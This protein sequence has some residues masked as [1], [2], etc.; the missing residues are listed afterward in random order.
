MQE[1]IKHIES[2]IIDQFLMEDNNRPW[3][4]GFSGG[5]DSTMLLQMVWNALKKIDPIVRS[6]RK[7]YV[8][9]NDTLVENPKIVD[10]I[11]RTLANIEK[12][13]VRDG[14]SLLVEKT[15]PKL[16]DTF[17]VNVIGR[18]YPAPNSIFRWCTERLKINPTTKRILDKID[19]N[20][21]VILFLGT[22]SDESIKRASSIKKHEF[23]TNR[24]RKH[25]L[26]KAFVYTP[27][28]DFLTEEVWQYL[29]AVPSPW[30]GSNRELITLYRNASG[31]DCPLVIDTTTP[32]CGNSR[33]GCWVC[34][35]V[36]RDK[37][38]EALI[39]NGEE[40]MLPLLELRDVLAESRDNLE[41]REEFRRNGQEA[42]GPYK[43]QYRAL[44][45][46][47]LLEAQRLTQM[48]EPDID[49]I[50][51][52]ELVAIQ[53]MWYRDSIFNFQVSNIYNNIYNSNIMKADKIEKQKKKETEILTLSCKKHPE[54]IQLIND[55]LN[56]QKT[57]ILLR[58]KV[59]LSADLE[60][61]LERFLTKTQKAKVKEYAN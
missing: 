56:V 34:T 13:A 26:P 3:I 10:F 29:L 40:W 8:I 23:G 51:N 50:T 36:K 37:S 49:L 54:H 14:I 9:C 16:E 44:I 47:K 46:Q 57:K 33:F 4:I 18:G 38:M 1:N 19:E 41:W 17:W 11:Y 30:N 35:V 42:P 27:I 60:T 45:L 6:Q 7:I 53:I 12:A 24:L 43:P 15:T 52:Q 59:G 39:D 61:Q 5:K 2:E 28:K 25:T 58:K 55:L 22:R 20:G 32:S 48:T 31:G 21:E